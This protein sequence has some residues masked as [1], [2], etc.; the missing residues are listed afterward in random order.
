MCHSKPLFPFFLILICLGDL[1]I[2]ISGVL[3]SPIIVLL[4]SSFIFVI[5][6]FMY[7]SGP[8]WVRKYLQL[9]VFLLDCPLYYYVVSFFV[10]CYSPCFNVYFVW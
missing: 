2:H 7:L 3:K 5:N 6:C 4:I 9:F 8:I 10:S 1:A